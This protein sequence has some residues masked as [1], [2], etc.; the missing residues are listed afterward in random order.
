MMVIDEI[1]Q[2][3]NST[4]NEEIY[5]H[6]KS[7]ITVKLN[8]Y[9]LV[10]EETGIVKYEMTESEKWYKMF[11]IA[12]KLQ[13]LSLRSLKYYKNELDRSI[14]A[15][16]KPLN[17]ITTDD[18]RYY[19]A[20]MQLS[21]TNNQTSIDNT[22]RVLNTFFQWLND[23]EYIP[24]NPCRRIKK[25][26]QKKTT[27]KA[28]TFE[29]IEKLKMECE[30]IKKD[31]Q[32]K[33][34]IAAVEF[35]LSTGVRAEEFVNVKI[36]DIN[37]ASGEVKVLGKG[38]KERTVY[39]NATAI[40]RLQDYLNNRLGSSEYAFS[41]LSK[42]YNKI[43]VEVLQRLVKDLGA[44]ANITNVHPHKFRRTCATI[45]KRRGMPIEEISKMLGH[46]DLG[47]TQIYVQVIDD[48]IKKSHEKYMN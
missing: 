32:R 34:A 38:N 31:I 33:R 12:K 21:G 23:E 35:L 19:L 3:I 44:K 13:G 11:F 42:P 20:C 24:I 41:G 2:E 40:L 25:V 15:I 43:G 16:K 27:K 46:E 1:L 45:A 10:K 6:L 18:I 7:F 39:L 47:T 36:K 22:R 4:C 26:K 37:F 28:F 30:N 48:D 8:S 9:R 29:E 14:N 5:Q 17:E